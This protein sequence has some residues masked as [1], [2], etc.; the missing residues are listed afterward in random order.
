MPPTTS[1]TS[2]KRTSKRV[3]HRRSITTSARWRTSRSRAR[4]ELGADAEDLT[5]F[6]FADGEW[7]ALDTEVAS[8]TDQRV[9]LEFETPGFSYFAVSATSDPTAAFDAPGEVEAGGDV[10]LDAS[11]SEDEYGEIVSYDWSVNGESLSGETTTATLDEAGDVDVELTVTNDA[12][13]TDTTTQT[14]SVL[15]ADG[16][17]GTDGTGGTDGTDEQPDDG[18]LGTGVIA[19]IVLL[20]IIAIAG[21]ALYSAQE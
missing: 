5:A 2:T 7:Q 1:S 18:G 17:D 14:V 19:G 8:E 12:G 20:I 11:A 16:T 21:V 6:R 4:P 3:S 9:T 10:E 15:E 13:E